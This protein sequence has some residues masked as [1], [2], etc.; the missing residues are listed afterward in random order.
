MGLG[1][2]GPES[3]EDGQTLKKHSEIGAGMRHSNLE[4]VLEAG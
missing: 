4:H 3:K 1:L 2:M